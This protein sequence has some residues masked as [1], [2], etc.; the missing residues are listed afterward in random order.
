MRT[1]WS[2]PY[3]YCRWL[4]GLLTGC[5]AKLNSRFDYAYSLHYHRRGNPSMALASFPE[6]EKGKFHYAMEKAA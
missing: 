2:G 4:A 3:V 5:S 6:G 1:G